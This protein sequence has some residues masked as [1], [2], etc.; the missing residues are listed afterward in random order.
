MMMTKIIRMNMPAKTPV[1]SK[2]ALS[3]V[4]LV[5]EAGRG[6]EVLADDRPDEREAD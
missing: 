3:L 5:A 4:D 2:H 1:T 6:P